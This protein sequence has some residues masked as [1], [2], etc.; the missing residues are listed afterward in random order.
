MLRYEGLRRPA[1][2][3]LLILAV[4]AAYF[5]GGRIGLLRQV[6]VAGAKVTPLWPPTGIAVACLL[7]LGL[8]I[9]PGIAL[10]EFLVIVSIGPFSPASAGI[11]AGST[12]APV[13]AC[14][15][16]RRAGFRIEMDRLRD[17]LALVFLGALG[18]MLVSATVGSTAL[19]LAGS[20]PLHEFWSTWS[21]WWAGDAMGVLVIA[22]LLLVARTVRLPRDTEAARWAEAVLVLAATATTMVLVTMTS[23]DLLFLVFPLLIWTAL[24]FQLVGAAPCVLLV[25]VVTIVAA[26]DRTGP[27]AHENI[28]E[29]MVTLQ[30]LNGAAALTTLLLAAVVTEQQSTYRKIEQACEAL[31]E[32]VARLAPH[33]R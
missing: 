18:G 3:G 22:P 5:T 11:V 29:I 17:G 28:F 25:S 9:W 26:T 6:V 12:L 24:R 27:F 32:V 14:L 8:R 4:A 23:L 21:A 20:V 19:V 33:D 1:T 15:M 31:A 2:A 30:A 13:C 7:T 10:G 16:L